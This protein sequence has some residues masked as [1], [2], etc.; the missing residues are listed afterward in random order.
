MI[1][2]MTIVL[3]EKKKIGEDEFHHPI[4]E[5]IPV[6][7]ENVLVVPASSTDV[8]EGLN[9]YGKKAVYTIAIPK[10]DEHKWEDVIVEFFGERWRTFG[11]PLEGIEEMIPLSW[12]KQVKVERYG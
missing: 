2:G 11:F 6:E 9:L 8:V 3:Y 1:E 5:E 12:N 7:V 10:G 4:Y